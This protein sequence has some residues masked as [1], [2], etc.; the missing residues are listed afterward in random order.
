MK[1]KT[2]LNKF[3]SKGFTLIE[4]LIVIAILGIMATAVLVAIN[5]TKKIDQSRDSNIKSDIAQISTGLQ[6]FYTTKGTVGTAYYP[7]TLAELVTA[8]ELKSVP[9]YLGTTD[10]T[11][12][13]TTGCTNVSPLYCTDV[14]VSYA[15][16][17]ELVAG[18][19]W[20]WRSATGLAAETTVALCIP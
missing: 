17:D 6:T 19:V 7:L 16:N 18:N 11:Y 15:L 4:L 5:P 14:S 10:Y 13:K 9:K 1:T 3:S 12:L 20:C 2:F 8:G